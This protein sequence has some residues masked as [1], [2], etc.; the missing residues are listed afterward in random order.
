MAKKK[1]AAEAASD[2]AEPAAPAAPVTAPV[3]Q[4][5]EARKAELRAMLAPDGSFLPSVEEDMRERGISA[6]EVLEV[7]KTGTSKRFI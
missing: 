3:V 1:Q 6:A 4:V 5:S 7:I 2:A